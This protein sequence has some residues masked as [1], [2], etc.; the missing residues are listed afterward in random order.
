M[1]ARF[2][3][4][5][6]GKEVCNAYTELNDPDEQRAR[7]QS[8]AEVGSLHLAALYRFL[9]KLLGKAAW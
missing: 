2:E 6:A 7:F 4:F 3:L 5:V 9:M 1:T 8:Q